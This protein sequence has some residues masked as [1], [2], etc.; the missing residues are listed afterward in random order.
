ML[1]LPLVVAGTGLALSQ[2][3]VAEVRESQAAG[4]VG[5]EATD[6][7][8]DLS[9]IRQQ[10]TA[11][12][13][14]F[15]QNDAGKIAELWTEDGEYVDDSGRRFVGRESVKNAYS[16]FFK[17]HPKAQIQLVID[18]L[19]L[20]G[21][22]VAI[23]DGRA[24]ADSVPPA[25]GIGKYTAVHTKV[26]GK[27][28]MASVRDSWTEAPESEQSSADLA[29]LIGNWRAEEHGIGMEMTCRWIASNR[30]LE[31]S[32]TTT[33]LDGS[34]SSGVQII[35]WNP[36]SAQVQ[37]WDFSPDGGHAVGV[38]YP[39]ENGWLAELQ[40]TTGEGVSTFA[41]NRIIR[42]DDSALAWQSVQ[43][44]IGNVNLGDTDE[45]V[46]KRHSGE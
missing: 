23:E 45:V 27:W 44:S 20:V 30:F 26:D 32:Y 12:V 11:F 39:T 3:T 29:W 24:I 36:I 4:T 15:N 1:A 35:G 14:A 7:S 5:V 25:T 43:R 28:L 10:S 19:H 21:P 9:A 40:G 8:P 2:E 34:T 41:V 46:I 16:E 13:N 38:W 22:S 42:L 17:D 37:S 18:A 33:Q 31:R 6:S